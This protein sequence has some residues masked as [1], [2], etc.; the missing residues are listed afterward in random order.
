MNQSLKNGLMTEFYKG[1]NNCP[2]L[3]LAVLIEEFSKET[4][5][6]YSHTIRKNNPIPFMEDNGT[7]VLGGFK[8][9]SKPEKTI[10]LMA[11][12]Y[13]NVKVNVATLL[14]AWDTAKKYAEDMGGLPGI[15]TLSDNSIECGWIDTNKNRGPCVEANIDD[16]LL[17][18]MYVDHSTSMH[19]AYSSQINAYH[20]ALDQL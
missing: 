5:N 8:D 13:T 2:I 12:H 15:R 3:S 19:K 6:N 18:P 9:A 1:L 10:T 20:R 14:R 17:T 11:G 16:V 7:L 4:V